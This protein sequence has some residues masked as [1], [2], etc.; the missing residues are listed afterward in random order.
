MGADALFALRI[1]S[2]QGSWNA[3]AEIICPSP[4]SPRRNSQSI[5]FGLM[6][7]E[8][9]HPNPRFSNVIAAGCCEGVIVG[10]PIGKEHEY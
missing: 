8:K 7:L 1:E 10:W 9:V 4:K 2:R 6:R 5:I 3:K